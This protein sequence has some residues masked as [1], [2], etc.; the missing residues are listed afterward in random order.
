VHVLARKGALIIG[1]GAGNTGS[2]DLPGEREACCVV[3]ETILEY[4]GVDLG[5][6]TEEWVEYCEVRNW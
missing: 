2:D 3:R 1:L 6:E 5:G 4:Q